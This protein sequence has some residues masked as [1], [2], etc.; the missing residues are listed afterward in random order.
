[1]IG[2]L[3]NLKNEQLKTK[4]LVEQV[5]KQQVIVNQWNQFM[6][7]N[8][9][10]AMGDIAKIL[11]TGRTKLYAFLRDNKVLMKDTYKNIPYQPFIDRELFKVKQRQTSIGYKAVTLATPKGADYIAKLWN[12]KNQ[13]NLG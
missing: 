10:I 12:K 11:D 5:E 3:T 2:L 9:L 7:T 6:D 1:M 8:G 13:L 4:A